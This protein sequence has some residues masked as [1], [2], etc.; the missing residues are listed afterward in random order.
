MTASNIKKTLQNKAAK[1]GVAYSKVAAI[2]RRGL[3]AFYVNL[4]LAA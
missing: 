2:Y 1:S 3:A 4:T